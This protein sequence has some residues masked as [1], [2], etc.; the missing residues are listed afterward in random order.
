MR[1]RKGQL[2]LCN[3]HQICLSSSDKYVCCLHLAPHSVCVCLWISKPMLASGR[4][5]YPRYLIQL[6]LCVEIRVGAD[7]AQ[8]KLILLYYTWRCCQQSDSW[9]TKLHESFW[10]FGGAAQWSVCIWPTDELV[11]AGG[12]LTITADSFV[13]VH[14]MKRRRERSG[15]PQLRLQ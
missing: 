10:S 13:P 7:V 2:S 9:K 15:D 12:L 6:S 11:Q 4:A 8:A 5:V 3:T 14:K 1:R